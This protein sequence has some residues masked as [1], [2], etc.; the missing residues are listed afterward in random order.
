MSVLHR[1]LNCQSKL[2]FRL[3]WRSDAYHHKRI[4]L[5]PLYGLAA[6]LMVMLLPLR[7]SGLSFNPAGDIPGG[8]EDRRIQKG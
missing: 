8:G 2:S 5:T 6:C 4:P 7:P 3:F 1:V